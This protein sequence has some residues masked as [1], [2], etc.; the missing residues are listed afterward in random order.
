MMA[1]A[2]FQ[3]VGGDG[4]DRLARVA[5]MV[6]DAV[7]LLNK[8]MDEIKSEKGPGTDDD[9]DAPSAPDGDAQ[10]PG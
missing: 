4:V 8:A 5:Q 1:R 2:D 3:P 6:T 7:A 9:G 10:Q